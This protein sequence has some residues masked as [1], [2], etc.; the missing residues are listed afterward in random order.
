MTRKTLK[1]LIVLPSP[2]NHFNRIR[3]LNLIR[4]FKKLGCH[5]DIISLYKNTEEKQQLQMIRHFVNSYHAVYQPVWWSLL[6]CLFALFLPIPLRVAYCFNPFL[7]RKLFNINKQQS[8]DII[9]IKRCR[10]AQYGACFSG[11]NV[12]L[13][14][15]DS[16]TKRYQNVLQEVKGYKKL[17]CWEEYLKHRFYEPYV[18]N[19][20]GKIIMCSKSDRDYLVQL[21]VKKKHFIVLENGVISEDWPFWG[22]IIKRSE[23]RLV[24]WWVMS[25]ETNI[26]SVK[27]FLDCVFPHLPLNCTYTIIGPNPPKELKNTHHNV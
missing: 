25:I 18:A 9:Y 2:P 10:M 27:Y 24:F 3:S 1:I 19:K 4:S 8:Y 7:Y 26:N 5:V 14:F 21:G 12:Y 20:Y 13:D 6:C 16:M 17:L 11:G 15:T 22:N 23:I